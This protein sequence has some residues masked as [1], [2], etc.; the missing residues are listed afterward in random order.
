[1][2]G[3]AVTTGAVPDIGCWIVTYY[4]DGPLEILAVYPQRQEAEARRH[5]MTH[6]LNCEAYFLR[7]G[8]EPSIH[9]RGSARRLFDT[10]ADA[11]ASADECIDQRDA[12]SRGDL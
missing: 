1:M 2:I 7:W 9:D 6:D 3:P 5:A 12:A 11:L 10:V 8:D 4:D